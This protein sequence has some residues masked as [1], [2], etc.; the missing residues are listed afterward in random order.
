MSLLLDARKKSQEAQAAQDGAG[1]RPKVEL[2]LEEHPNE[3]KPAV[4][5]PQTASS[6]GSS[7]TARIA[8]KNLFSAKSSSTASAIAGINRKL[9]LALGGTVI[10]LTAGGSYVWYVSSATT[11]PSHPAVRAPAP[12]TNAQQTPAIADTRSIIV[13]SPEIVSSKPA[14]TKQPMRT[15]RSATKAPSQQ[16]GSSAPM[17]IEQHPPESIDPLLNSAYLA[18]REGKFDQAQ[19]LY[20]EA[21]KLDERNNDALLGLAAIA[22]RRGADSTAA[23]Y[24][25]KVLELN[26]RDPVANAGMSALTTDDNIESRIKILLYEQQDSSALHF[27]LGNHYASQERWGEAQQAYFNAY[28][29]E[30]KNAGLVFNLAVSLERLGQKKLAA[31]YYQSA[32]QLDPSHSGGF[33]HTLISQRI[34]EL[35]R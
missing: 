21:L 15:A 12:T 9:L 19:Q 5:V 24:Y 29:L 4:A 20:R 25:A 22:Q 32:L 10:L 26:P 34:E 14:N 33:D 2:S 17:H 13:P 18:Y 31:Q 30:P 8:G 27:A 6:S 11:P 16:S 23:N 35:T 3:A 7:E 28:K 1:T